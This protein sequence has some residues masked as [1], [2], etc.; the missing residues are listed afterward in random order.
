MDG[1]D[2][3]LAG[4]V[5][6]A[7]TAALTPAA[8]RLARRVGAVDAPRARGLAERET[9]LLGGLAI[10]T[11]VVV[12]AWIWLPHSGT[13]P[14]ILL[15]ALVITLVGALDDLLDLPAA[16]KFLGQAGA[17]LIPV[18]NDVV[19]RTVT[20]PFVGSVD[21]GH[22]AEPLTLLGI[23]FLINVV[24]FSDGVDGLAAGVGAIAATSFAI[25]AF[26]LGKPNAAVLA[27]IVGGAALGFLVHNFHPASVFMGDCGSNLLGYLLG[28]VVVEGTLKTNALIALVGPLVVLAVPFLDTG[29]VVAK[30]IKY[31][32]PVY[33]ADR[34]HFHHRMAN[35][36]FSQRRTVL[37]LYAWMVMMAGIAIALRFIPYSEADGRLR[38]GWAAVMG[39]LLLVALLASIYLVYVL[40]IFKFRRLTA[41]RM[42]LARPEATEEEVDEDVTG[43][44]ETGE[45]EAVR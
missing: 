41:L 40:E 20:L 37:Y 14:A 30:R 12:A 16:A 35:I 9:P 21:L 39:A 10:F 38:A 15:G 42:R 27:A 11:G 8:G 25:I 22:A 36:G 28:V 32:R 24:N 1:V 23:V 44:L 18:L 13:L 2:A 29:F 45:W 26:D 17:V 43:R 6:A 31:R 34:W 5:A 4:A 33:A 3:L 19:V 7:V